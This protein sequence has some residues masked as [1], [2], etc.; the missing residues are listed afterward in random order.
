VCSGKR[1]GDPCHYARRGSKAAKLRSTANF[2]A[3]YSGFC[4]RKRIIDAVN[5]DF[6]F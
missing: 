3:T 1:F 4:R 5:H 6:D 2:D